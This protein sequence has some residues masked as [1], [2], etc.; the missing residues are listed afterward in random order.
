MPTKWD[1]TQIPSGSPIILL[2]GTV[3]ESA[4]AVGDATEVP[5]TSFGLW[6][7]FMT[8]QG[9]N[10]AYTLTKTTYDAMAGLLIPRAVA[11]SAGLLNYF[12]RGQMA[13]SLPHE[14]VYSIIDQAQQYG[15]A[16]AGLDRPTH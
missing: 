7:Q 6:D 8:A 14:G 10:P 2:R 11:Y 16:Q 15:E 1:G 9:L 12:C 4:S 13:I 5:L 3:H